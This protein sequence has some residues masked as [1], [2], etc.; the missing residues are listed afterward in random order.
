MED[1]VVLHML[2]VGFR[3]SG[4]LAGSG[5][6]RG[7]SD[8]GMA[9]VCTGR[10]GVGRPPRR[11]EEQGRRCWAARAGTQR[12][13]LTPGGGKRAPAA[14]DPALELG[15]PRGTQARYSARPPGKA[16]SAL[17]DAIRGGR[18]RRRGPQGD[19]DPASAHR[20]FRRWAELPGRG[21]AGPSEPVCLT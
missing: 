3:P 11:L 10:P 20:G 2:Q 18:R 19:H 4:M 6:P 13:P 1:D 9:A 8:T 21:G 5:G 12:P 15:R 14:R 7:R 16:S 17:G